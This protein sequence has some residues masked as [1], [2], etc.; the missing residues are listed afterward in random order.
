MKE[1]KIASELTIDHRR[2]MCVSSAYSSIVPQTLAAVV[3]QIKCTESWGSL[4]SCNQLPIHLRACQR[5]T[6]VHEKQGRMHVCP[7][8]L[9]TLLNWK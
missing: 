2:W 6:I 8:S 3:L 7:L 5:G 9:V 4:N 1:N